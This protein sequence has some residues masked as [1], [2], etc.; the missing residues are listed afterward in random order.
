MSE[1]SPRSSLVR[2]LYTHN[3]FYATDH[4][5]NKDV[6][7]ASTLFTRGRLDCRPEL[8]NGGWSQ[9]LTQGTRRW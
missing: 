2:W 6:A 8:A 1:P 5:N 4:S 3:P 7:T 9:S